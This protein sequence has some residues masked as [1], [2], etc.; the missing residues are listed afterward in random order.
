VDCLDKIFDY[1]KTELC[2]KPKATLKVLEK[3]AVLSYEELGGLSDPG[4]RGSAHN[5]V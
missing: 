2:K 1:F 3:F 4:P 5:V